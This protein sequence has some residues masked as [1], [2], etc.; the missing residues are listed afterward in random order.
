MRN[1][2]TYLPL[3][4]ETLVWGAAV[5]ST[6]WVR[7]PGG[8]EYP[9]R[10]AGHPPDHV[11]TWERGRMLESWQIV[12]IQEGGGR[13]ES[14]ETGLQNVRAG[15]VFILFPGVWHR[16]APD[17]ETGWVESWIEIE[18]PVLERLRKLGTLDP[19]RA[20]FELGDQPEL[21][22]L[23]DRC[24]VLAQNAPPGYAEQLAAMGLQVL[25]SVLSIRQEAD[26]PPSHP[27]KIIQH[28]RTLLAERCD[29]P[30]RIRDLARELGIGE[31]H[32]RRVFKAHTGLSPKRYAM[33]L[34]LRRVRAQLRM[35]SDTLAEIAEKTGFHSAYHLSAEFKKHTGISPSEWRRTR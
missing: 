6:G 19:A 23:M 33:D 15:T 10:D 17:P 7:T 2:I 12:H 16:Y 32:F 34:R 3:A 8:S 27:A 13:F 28:A 1:P 9:A 20:V 24:R 26:A 30:F 31:S 11:F 29:E 35:S 21:T 4:K 18:G 22:E 14:R 5:T 25:A